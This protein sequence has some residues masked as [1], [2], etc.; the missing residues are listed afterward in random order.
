MTIKAPYLLLCTTGNLIS[1]IVADS[2]DPICFCLLQ[3]GEFLVEFNTEEVCN[4]AETQQAARAA[5]LGGGI[6]PAITPGTHAG[7]N[8][9]IQHNSGRC[10]RS[11]YCNKPAGHPGFCMRT[12]GHGRGRRPG[13]QV[14][15]APRPPSAATAKRLPSFDDVGRPKRSRRPSMKASSS[16]GV[17]TDN[18]DEEADHVDAAYSEFDQKEDEEEV[19]HPISPHA[20]A[21]YHDDDEDATEGAMNALEH[22]PT[23]GRD[24]PKQQ[25]LPLPAAATTATPPPEPGP[26]VPPIFVMAPD[27]FAPP[28]MP[29]H[30]RSPLRPSLL[31]KQHSLPLPPAPRP[32]HTDSAAS[33]PAM[34]SMPSLGMDG[35]GLGGAGAT[36]AALGDPGSALPLG[37]LPPTLPLS[38]PHP[39]QA[40]DVA[41]FLANH[42]P[43]E[44]AN[45]AKAHLPQGLALPLPVQAPTL[46][47]A[48]GVEAAGGP[49]G[50]DGSPAGG[51]AHAALPAAPLPLF[52]APPPPH[53]PGLAGGHHSEQAEFDYMSF[54]DGGK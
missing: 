6:T 32:H 43:P 38:V 33:L 8:P 40:V 10:T 3:A 12:P 49:D 15:A 19:M 51:H 5:G 24:M 46:P 26:S 31:A 50:T 18:T 29:P 48:P 39:N 4:A 13:S 21:M 36:A 20:N 45:G 44:G 17:E 11:E 54:L 28:Q 7:I 25:S 14:Q 53:A 16:Y 22:Y 42:S 34:A 37:A 47:E 52:G 23:S 1:R 2:H 41:A 9:L 35:A 30:V 27:Q